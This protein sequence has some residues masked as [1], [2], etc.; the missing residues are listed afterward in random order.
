MTESKLKEAVLKEAKICVL[1]RNLHINFFHT[2][3]NF[4]SSILLSTSCV[5]ETV[6]QILINKD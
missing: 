6:P 1:A 5:I 2:D 4:T 3:N